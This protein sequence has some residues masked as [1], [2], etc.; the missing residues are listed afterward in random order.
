MK[1]APLSMTLSTTLL[2]IL[3]PDAECLLCWVSLMLNFTF[4]IVVLNV[5]FSIVMLNV[6]FSIVM[7]NIGV[8]YYTKFQ[9]IM[10]F[11]MLDV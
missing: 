10:L 9:K 3:T 5:T 8:P 2:R 4:S 11:Q 7:L 6:A 1:N